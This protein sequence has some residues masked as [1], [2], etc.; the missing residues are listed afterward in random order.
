MGG[1]AKKPRVLVFCDYFLP[2]YRAGGPITT[3]KNTVTALK[4]EF[5]FYVVTANRDYLS[6]EKYADIKEG[7]FSKRFGCSV[8]YVDPNLI[9]RRLIIDIVDQVAPDS[10]YLNSLF[11]FHFSIKVLA[12]RIFHRRDF[13]PTVLCPRG[14]LNPSALQKGYI[15]KKVYLNAARVFGLYRGI[16]WQATN[17]DEMESI[18]AFAGRG[19]AIKLA[20]NLS[21]SPD[22]ELQCE[23][24][25]KEK[26]RIRLVFA[27][28]INKIKNLGFIL[29]V[30]GQVGL[31]VELKVV[32]PVDDA[33]YWETCLTKQER[34]PSNIK[35]TYCGEMPP[36]RLIDAIRQ[37][38]AL[39]LPTLGEN[40]G[41]VIFEALAVGRP[42][43]ISDRTPWSDLE[44][45][46]AGWDIG[47]DEPARWVRAVTDACMLDRG[48]W[49]E[50]CGAALT[51]AQ[52]FIA[53]SE[54]ERRNI[55]L[56]R[57]PGGSGI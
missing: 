21:R 33:D 7:S 54:V 2:G 32:G 51:L 52:K 50:M 56:F 43:L 17:P 40:F 5:D 36:D 15:K 4:D 41:H 12:A 10:I 29:D 8:Y 14:E 35:V 18:A 31:P 3:L 48:A 34:L 1:F 44:S 6:T 9:C 39:V 53:E 23:N 46:N 13:P 37:C 22:A 16:L 42:V 19:G 20:S 26:G 45:A 24:V 27:A 47:L 30:L 11:S 49:I 57:P 25:A 28:R 38:H 55:E